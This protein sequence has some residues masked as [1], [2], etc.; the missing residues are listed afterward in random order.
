M[1]PSDPEI[2]EEVHFLDRQQYHRLIQQTI[3]RLGERGRVIVVG[4]GGMVLLRDFSDVLRVRIV[5]SEESRAERYAGEEGITFR[6]ALHQ[7]R[8]SDRRRSAFVSRNYH[9]NWDDTALYHMVINSEHT[10]TFM[11]ASAIASAAVSYTHL[12][13]PTKRIV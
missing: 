3:R 7:V 10:S 9:V 2:G 1:P 4:R 11:A 13:L 5:A 6:E 8:T 12:T